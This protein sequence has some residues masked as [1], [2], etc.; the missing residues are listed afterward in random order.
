[1]TLFITLESAFIFLSFDLIDCKVFILTL[2]FSF[3]PKVAITAFLHLYAD[4]AF[5]IL[6]ELKIVILFY[7]K[8]KKLGTFFVCML[9]MHR[10]DG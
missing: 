1:M 7:I 4:Y 10:P 2:F 9:E 6:E 5:L 3:F 8:K